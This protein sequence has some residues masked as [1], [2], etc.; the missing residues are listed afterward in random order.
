[1]N[2][3]RG[4]ILDEQHFFGQS[5]FAQENPFCCVDLPTKKYHILNC[6]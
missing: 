3:T 1:M 4:K 5:V 6:L 2:P